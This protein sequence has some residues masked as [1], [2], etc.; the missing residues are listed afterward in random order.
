MDKLEELS[1]LEN[2]KVERHLKPRDFGEVTAAQL[3]HFTD[4]SEDGY[5]AV[6]YLLL[7]NAHYQ[8]HSAIVMGKSRIA[9]LKTVSI[10]RMELTAATMA[11]RMDTLWRK[12]LHMQLHDSIFWRDSTSVLK[13]IKNETS[14]FRIFVANRVSE[15]LKL[16]QASQ[17]R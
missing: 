8:V 4:A 16:S 2:F 10:P 17:W 14:R 6:T 9:P 15:I 1:Q 11:S 13:Y 5:G 7:H 12:E 3:H